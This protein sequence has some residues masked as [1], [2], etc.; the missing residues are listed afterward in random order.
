MS[1]PI[2]SSS[3][4]TQLRLVGRGPRGSVT[5][6]LAGGAAGGEVRRPRGAEPPVSHRRRPDK[7]AELNSTDPRWVLAVRTQQVLQGAMLR[8]AERQNLLR[9][10][11]LMGL[12]PF[13]ANLV[14]AIVQ[15]QARR[16]GTLGAAAESLGRVPLREK[17]VTSP[18][19]WRVLRWC[20]AILS[21]ELL[22][23]WAII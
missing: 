11:R 16:G 1:Q 5:L 3:E 2:S 18:V 6:R 17:P 8:P 13:D 23:V 10:G 20:T 21:A 14:I 9:V 12:N 19:S 22:I 7:P 4:R 15:D